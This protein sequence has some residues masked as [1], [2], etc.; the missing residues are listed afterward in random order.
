MDRAVRGSWQPHVLAIMASCLTAGCS[1]EVRLNLVEGVV[2]KSAQTQKDV[3][4]QFRPAQGGRSA[5]GK[6]DENGKYTLDF[7]AGRAGAPVGHYRVV[8]MTGGKIDEYGS[9]VTPRKTVFKGEFEVKSGP[10]AIDI[11]IP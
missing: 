9:E 11:A 10:N 4:V 7:A 3:W 1:S 5:E 2:T 8:V 6:T